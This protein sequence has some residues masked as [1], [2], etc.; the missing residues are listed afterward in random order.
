[1]KMIEAAHAWPHPSRLASCVEPRRAVRLRE[2][3]APA[4]DP[5]EEGGADRC[6]QE[7]Y[8]P[9]FVKFRNSR[10]IILAQSTRNPNTGGS[11]E[12]EA[13]RGVS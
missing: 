5:E 2:G 1:M 11:E 10:D 12:Q 3:S 6:M 7:T 9:K 8:N 4:L 13:Q